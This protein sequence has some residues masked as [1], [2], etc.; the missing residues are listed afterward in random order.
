LAQPV[1][2]GSS[3]SY[4]VK[5]PSTDPAVTVDSAGKVK[6]VHP[7]AAIIEVSFEGHAVELP[8]LVK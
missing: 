3:A 7:G 1:E 5:S 2:L 8:V 6:S 4:R